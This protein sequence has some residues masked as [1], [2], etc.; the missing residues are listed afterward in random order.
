M[1]LDGVE[2]QKSE[3]HAHSEKKGRRGAS[4]KNSSM[5]IVGGNGKRERNTKRK[6]EERPWFAITLVLKSH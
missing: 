1:S 2:K 3:I 4:E 6:R 5:F